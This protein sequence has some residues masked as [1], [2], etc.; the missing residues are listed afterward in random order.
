MYG[1]TRIVVP[2]TPTST[3]S[4]AAVGGYLKVGGATGIEV[5]STNNGSPA[6]TRV[7]AP[8]GGY[9]A[10]PNLSEAL[11]PPL[12]ANVDTSGVDDQITWTTPNTAG[13]SGADPLPHH[14]AHI[15][16][17]VV[18][19]L[20]HHVVHILLDDVDLHDLVLDDVVHNIHHDAVHHLVH[21]HLD[22]RPAAGARAAVAYR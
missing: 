11:S 2:T 6:Y 22:H 4:R 10:M 3:P 18:H 15:D 17:D 13:I 9:D 19:Q 14:A 20:V 16:D 5:Q 1:P 8:G 21:N 12:L 7:H